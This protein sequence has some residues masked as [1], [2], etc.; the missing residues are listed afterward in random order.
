[1]TGQGAR[2]TTVQADR[3]GRYVRVQLSGPCVL[4]LAEVQVWGADS[5][6]TPPGDDV[7]WMVTDQLGTPR[8]VMDKTGSLARM[9]RHDYLPFG[10]ELYAGSG[11]R[12]TTQGYSRY[13]GM[14]Q[15]FTSYERDDE[16]GLDYAQARYYASEQGRF[17][18]VAPVSGMVG[19]PQNWNGYTYTLNNPVNLTDPTGMFANA[20][21]SGPSWEVEGYGDMWKRRARWTDEIERARACYQEMVDR[22]F[23][24]LAQRRRKKRVE[25]QRQQQ[26]QPTLTA[27]ASEPVVTFWLNANLGTD[28][29]GNPMY[30]TGYAAVQQIMLYED[31]KPVLGLVGTERVEGLKGEA[32]IQNGR[33]VV[34]QEDGSIPDIVSR[35]PQAFPERIT[36]ASGEMIFKRVGQAPVDITTRQTLTVKLPQGGSAQIIFDRRLTNLDHKGKVRPSGSMQSEVPTNFTLRVVSEVTVN[37]LP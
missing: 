5:M 16:T 25:T 15:H 23:A 32:V 36:H 14:R 26:A 35:G 10:E 3:T 24:N 19:N 28:S 31:G 30:F 34:A 33:P 22:G 13:D 29:Q 21:S 4:T 1:M 6:A 8:M 7:R 12:A 20:E 11:G 9:T 17:T 2:P 18:G 27:T 37:R